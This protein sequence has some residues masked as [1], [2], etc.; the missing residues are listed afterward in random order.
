MQHVAEAESTFRTR[1]NV[2][3]FPL[4]GFCLVQQFGQPPCYV[5]VTEKSSTTGTV[6]IL[7]QVDGDGYEPVFVVFIM[8]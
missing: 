1:A 4:T 2:Y 5:R 7:E 8:G 6:L 3:P